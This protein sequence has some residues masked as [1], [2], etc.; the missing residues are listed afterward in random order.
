MAPGNLLHIHA[1]I[2]THTHQM[3][4]NIDLIYIIVMVQNIS[5]VCIIKAGY[6]LFLVYM[7]PP[8]ALSYLNSVSRKK[9]KPRMQKSWCGIL[10]LLFSY[11][12][13]QEP[14]LELPTD[15]YGS[16][17]NNSYKCLF[18]F[19]SSKRQSIEKTNSPKQRTMFMNL[20]GKRKHTEITSVAPV[21]H[22]GIFFLRK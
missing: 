22:N 12:S 16:C 5:Q 14:Y 2:H 9:E 1:L 18:L 10:I 7:W 19:D 15:Y 17:L 13:S 20:I 21:T 3:K 11:K 8:T 6:F 4:I